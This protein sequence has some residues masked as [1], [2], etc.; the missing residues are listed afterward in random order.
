MRSNTG[1]HLWGHQQLTNFNSPPAERPGAMKLINVHTLEIEAFNAGE[2]VPRYAILSHTWGGDEISFHEWITNFGNTSPEYLEKEGYLKII[3]ACSKT[4]DDKL[5]YLWVDTICIDKSSSAEL[6]EAINSMF[7]WY[8]RATVCIVY[9]AD[10]EWED[11]LI[12][13]IHTNQYSSFGSSRWFTR[14][15]TLQELLAPRKVFFFTKEWTEIGT[16]SEL[17]FKISKITGIDVS[18]LTDTR[19]IW[20]ASIAA[21]MSWASNRQTTRPEDMAYCLLGIFDINMPLLYGEGSRAFLRLQEEIIKS[22]DDHTIF[23]WTWDADKTPD[24]WQSVLAPSPSVFSNSGS[25]VATHRNFE[26]A[27]YQVTNVGLRIKLPV[28]AAV[29]CLCAMLSVIS[30][31]DADPEHKRMMCLPL[32]EEGH[33]YRRCPFPSR[34]FPVHRSMVCETK[35]MYLL[36]KISRNTEDLMPWPYRHLFE[37]GF[38]I[39]ILD[40]SFSTDIN[41]QM[42]TSVDCLVP[43]HKQTPTSHISRPVYSTVGFRNERFLVFLSVSQSEGNLKWNCEVLDPKFADHN[44]D[45][46]LREFEV[47]SNSTENIPDGSFHSALSPSGTVQILIALDGDIAGEDSRRIRVIYL[48]LSSKDNMSPRMQDTWGALQRSLGD[49]QGRRMFL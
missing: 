33:I 29:N 12:H 10:V 27:P 39:N 2:Q 45:D 13:K 41:R 11:E 34:P 38:H 14:G 18:Y 47:Y 6:S 35:E 37:Y 8:E 4:R 23:C 36:Y 7:A 17:M 49:V 40:E 46:W 16:K 25:F 1:L 32:M 9:M 43:Q 19:R 48:V 24:Q 31:D 15:W 3:N 30:T 42:L 22:A 28:V 20:S 5:R 26:S 44:V 21:R